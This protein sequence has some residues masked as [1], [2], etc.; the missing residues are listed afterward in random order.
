MLAGTNDVNYQEDLATAPARLSTLI[1]EIFSYSPKAAIIVSDIPLILDSTLEPLAKTYNA[2]ILTMLNTRIAA[3]QKLVH[4][5]RPSTFT[6]ADMADELHPSKQADLF[7][8]Q[9]NFN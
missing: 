3:G 7:V 4:V 2:G 1:D 9:F 6:S 8:W 5:A